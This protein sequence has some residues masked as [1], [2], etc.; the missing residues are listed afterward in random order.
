M[1]FLQLVILSPLG[2]VDPHATLSDSSYPP[3]PLRHV[4]H[5]QSSQL[6]RSVDL[7]GQ[8]E[9]T[10]ARQEWCMWVHTYIS[11]VH[12]TTC[13]QG[14]TT[15]PSCLGGVCNTLSRLHVHQ[16]RLGHVDPQGTLLVRVLVVGHLV[17]QGIILLYNRYTISCSSIVGYSITFGS[18]GPTCNTIIQ[19][20]LPPPHLIHVGHTQPSQPVMSVYL[21]G[22]RER[23]VARQ[24]WC[25]W[26]HTYISVVHSTTCI[27]GSMSTPSC[28]GRECN[29]LSRLYVHQP[30]LGHV[31]PQGTLLVQVI[32]VGHLVHQ[33]IML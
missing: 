32:V 30:R 1:F 27:L 5:K 23:D 9:L 3:P 8:R 17:Q 24:E 18:C 15:T 10:V 28:L 33:F 20:L 25:T 22:Q 14:S 7:N 2:H 29:T 13:I 16:Q 4:G 11:D 26:V 31:E 21:D 19:L 12:G 6:V